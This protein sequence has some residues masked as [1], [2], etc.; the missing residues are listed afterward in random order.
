MDELIHWKWRSGASQ[1][2]AHESD[3]QVHIWSAGA[4]MASH[5]ILMNLA[6]LQGIFGPLS[7]AARCN[8]MSNLKSTFKDQAISAC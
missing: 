4:S 8:C 5:C 6:P 1:Q 7:C 3:G 2:F